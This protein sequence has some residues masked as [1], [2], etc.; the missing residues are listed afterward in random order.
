MIAQ[1]RKAINPDLPAAISWLPGGKSARN[2]FSLPN[3]RLTFKANRASYLFTKT[4]TS[5]AFILTVILSV[6]V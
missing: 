1:I 5:F 3:G 2:A 6:C 4:R